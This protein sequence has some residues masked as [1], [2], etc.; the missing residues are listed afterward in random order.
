MAAAASEDSGERRNDLSER[1][2]TI[3]D[4]S[5]PSSEAYRTLRTSLIY[6]LV[7]APPKVIIMT[8]PGPGEGKSTT[9]ANLAVVLAQADK[10]VLLMDCD[11]RKPVMHKVFGL[12][13]FVG[14]VNVLVGERKIE[15]VWQEPH[16][17]LK[18]V[19]VGTLPPNPAE[20]LGSRRFAQLVGE[21]REQFDY[22]LIDAPPTQLVS[23]P[24]ILAMQGDGI[25]LVLDSQKTRK[26][27]L[28]QAV[29]NLETVGAKVLGTVMNNVKV[30]RGSYYGYRYE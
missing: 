11:L 5:N 22:V 26:G 10:K 1:L 6:A 7:D 19:T 14:V 27:T 15:E 2:I 30:T 20:L 4:P 8:S 3:T 17:N 29:H 12:R 16:P 25:L 13:N 23:D 28:R 18:V 24:A 9:C 21:M